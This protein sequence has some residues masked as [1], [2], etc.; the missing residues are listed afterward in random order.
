MRRESVLTVTAAG[1]KWGCDGWGSDRTAIITSSLFTLHWL[2]AGMED[3]REEKETLPSWEGRKELSKNADKTRAVM[4]GE[5]NVGKTENWLKKRGKDPQKMRVKEE[6]QSRRRELQKKKQ[7]WRKK[8]RRSVTSKY[9]KR[10]GNKNKSHVMGG[11][12]I[13]GGKGKMTQ[14]KCRK[15]PEHWGRRTDENRKIQM[16]F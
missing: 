14:N 2:T 6:Q 10:V 12:G 9:E 4:D 15:E 13:N 1:I 16:H 11:Q 5:N 7:Y 3:W 8:N